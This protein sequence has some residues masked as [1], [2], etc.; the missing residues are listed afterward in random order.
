MR[1]Q[2]IPPTFARSWRRSYRPPER[3]RIRPPAGVV[4]SGGGGGGAG[5]VLPIVEPVEPPPPADPFTGAIGAVVP[6]TPPTV[7]DIGSGLP[8]PVVGVFCDDFDR[9]DRDLSGDNGWQVIGQNSLGGGIVEILDR[10]AQNNI[11]LEAYAYQQLTI[12]GTNQQEVSAWVTSTQEGIAQWI[13]LVINGA[14]NASY[15]ERLAGVIL[16]LSWLPNH[17]RK[18]EL[19]QQLPSDLTYVLLG[20]QQLV[21]Q[22]GPVETGYH[23]R[24]IDDGATNALQHIRLIV[25]PSEFGIIAA[26]YVNQEDD[27]HPTLEARLRVDMVSS[28]SVAGHWGFGFSAATANTLIVARFCG[29]DYTLAIA[30]AAVLESSQPT[31]LELRE[32]VKRR[33]AGG[34]GSDLDD[35]HVDE[36]VSEQI[37]QIVHEL[38][39]A[40]W[41]LERQEELTLSADAEGYVTMPSYVERV[42]YIERLGQK[43]PSHWIYSHHDGSNNLVL[44]LRLGEESSQSTYLVKFRL[45]WERSGRPNDVCILPR[46]HMWTAVWGV[47]LTLA[48]TR[49]RKPAMAESY[50]GLYN[51]R[52][53]SLRAEARRHW[54][55]KRLRLQP[56]RRAVSR[57]YQIPGPRY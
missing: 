41:F 29:N 42:Y 32:I 28:T 2:R 4:T 31:I 6:T 23:G 13:D 1:R 16:R 54:N 57:P 22:G 36:L 33:Y 52:L 19:W 27:D 26:A 55:Q 50:G 14:W 46:Q 56:R 35:F 51:S 39:E 30:K 9:T 15:A 20:T 45:R 34:S 40:C 8:D 24:L 21:A 37:E 25:R 11:Q 5:G 48:S 7:G 44:R 38:G 3:H 18:I 17:E 12:P 43:Q 53:E 47:C 49:D 10:A